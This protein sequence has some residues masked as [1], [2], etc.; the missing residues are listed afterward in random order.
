MNVSQGRHGSASKPEIQHLGGWGRGLKSSRPAAK[1]STKQEPCLKEKK[2]KEQFYE[3][4]I[5]KAEN[6]LKDYETTKSFQILLQYNRLFKDNYKRRDGC[7]CIKEA[8]VVRN[9]A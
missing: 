2:K 4:R 5:S 7:K 1:L 6:I 3:R 9:I 8:M